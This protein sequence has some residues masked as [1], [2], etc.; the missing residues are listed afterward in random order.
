MNIYHITSIDDRNIFR[1]DR[2]SIKLP[3]FVETIERFRVV[4]LFHVVVL[5]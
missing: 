1:L 4:V 2:K 3:R 5:C